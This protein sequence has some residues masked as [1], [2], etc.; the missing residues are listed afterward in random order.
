ME[1]LD[2]WLPTFAHLSREIS[3][4]GK[5]EADFGENM[6]TIYAV[7]WLIGLPVFMLAVVGPRRNIESV[8]NFLIQYLSAIGLA[9]SRY[10]HTTNCTTTTEGTG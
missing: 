6:P 4:V 1:K 9:S 7:D 5:N 10:Q 3:Y 8:Y 2:F